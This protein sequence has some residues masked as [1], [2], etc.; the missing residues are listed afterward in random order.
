MIEVQGSEDDSLPISRQQV[1]SFFK[2][3]L[4]VGGCYLACVDHALT[5]MEWLLGALPMQEHRIMR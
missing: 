3:P 5:D 2:H 1:H 4:H